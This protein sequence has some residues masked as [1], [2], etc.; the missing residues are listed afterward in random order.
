ME[1]ISFLEK[2]AIENDG[3]NIFWGKRMS[4]KIM[5]NNEA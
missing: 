4:K 3:E 2:G 1:R 5:E